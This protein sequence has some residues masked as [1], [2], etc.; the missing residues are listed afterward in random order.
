MKKKISDALPTQQSEIDLKRVD[1]SVRTIS[2][3]QLPGDEPRTV[4]E[5]LESMK[6]KASSLINQRLAQILQSQTRQKKREQEETSKIKPIR[7]PA[8]TERTHTATGSSD[9]LNSLSSP[10]LVA[11]RDSLKKKTQPILQRVF[12]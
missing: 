6:Q 9:L 3:T 8:P 5:E 10:P 2:A 12:K 1:Q 7:P 11:Q 4:N